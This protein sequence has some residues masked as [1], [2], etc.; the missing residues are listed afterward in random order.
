MILVSAH[1]TMLLPA[2]NLGRVYG[3][4]IVDA[5]VK[6]IGTTA[7]TAALRRAFAPRARRVAS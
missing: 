5:I 3:V 7:F 2:R 1:D 4:E 6:P